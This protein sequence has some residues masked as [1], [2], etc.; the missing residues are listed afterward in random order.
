MKRDSTAIP[1]R[2]TGVE[3]QHHHH[4]EPVKPSFPKLGKG[5]EQ[6]RGIKYTLAQLERMALAANR[7]LAEA[8][9]EVRAAEGKR[10]QAGL[11][12]NPRVG[13]QGEELRGC[14]ATAQHRPGG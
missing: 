12:P 13:F 14:A 11:Y 2:E 8:E 10:L 7:T 5:Q 1:V 4:I 3:Q 6:I 9:A